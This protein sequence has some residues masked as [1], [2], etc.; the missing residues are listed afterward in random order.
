MA[1]YDH[2]HG[3]H[4]GAVKAGELSLPGGHRPLRGLPQQ[5]WHR[6]GEGAALEDG[7]QEGRLAT[8]ARGCVHDGVRGGTKHEGGEEDNEAGRGYS[9][10]VPRES[11]STTNRSDSEK[12]PQ[13]EDPQLPVRL[14]LENVGP[15]W[16]T[17][18]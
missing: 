1:E 9:T 12:W 7:V 3:E 5:G 8:G 10:S 16:Q 4:T 13:K 18:V 14:L 15:K 17:V 11:V 2:A 6:A